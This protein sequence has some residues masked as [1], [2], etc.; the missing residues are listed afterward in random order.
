MRSANFVVYVIKYS[1]LTLYFRV[2][3][4]TTDHTHSINYSGFEPK[5]NKHLAVLFLRHNVFEIDYVISIPFSATLH[6]IAYNNRFPS[7][8][9]R[10]AARL[11]RRLVYFHKQYSSARTNV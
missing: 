3:K 5:I 4:T 7:L 8:L 6:P 1:P 9:L 11:R 10:Q 2:G